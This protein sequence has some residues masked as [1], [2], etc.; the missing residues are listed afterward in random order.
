[1]QGGT[2]TTITWSWAPTRCWTSTPP[3][4]SWTS[5]GSQPTNFDVADNSGSTKITIVGNNQTY[6]LN[7]VPLNQMSINNII[8]L[9]SNTIA[10]WQ[11]AI[12]NA[13]PSVST[14]TISIAS[15][16]TT[17]GNSGT[18]TPPFTVSLSQAA[19]GSG[20]GGYATANGTA[21]AGSD[22]TATSGTLTFAPG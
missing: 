17:E 4:T 20:D 2:T 15:A 8:A 11:N 1:M 10:K 18:T 9:D 12:A 16:S 5:A 13:G 19:L 22:Y 7:N 14:P 3:L 21:T 6:T